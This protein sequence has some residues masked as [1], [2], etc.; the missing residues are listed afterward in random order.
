M[1]CK[2]Y[3]YWQISQA[4][5]F[6][7]GFLLLFFS[8]NL[9]AQ[10]FSTLSLG[11]NFSDI[12]GVQSETFDVNR[13]FYVGLGYHTLFSDPFSFG[14]ELNMNR[15][16]FSN[17]YL[18]SYATRD[19]YYYNHVDQ[20]SL[21][22]PFLLTLHTNRFSFETGP[23]LEF[24]LRSRQTEIERKV[25][26]MPHEEGVIENTYIDRQELNNTELGI[27]FGI[28]Y[29]ILSNIDLSARYIQVF[30]PPGREYNWQRQRVIQAGL[31]INFGKSFSPRKLNFDRGSTR[32]A[33]ADYRTLASSNVVRVIYRYMGEGN[34][35]VF[36]FR[37]TDKQHYNLSEM[38][39]GNSS[40]EL[41]L[42]EFESMVRNAGFPFFA[43]MR[44]SFE[45]PST[46]SA[47]NYHLNFEISRSGNWE[48]IIEY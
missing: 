5:S 32:T 25:Y 26:K 8:C 38:M 23:H 40:G 20:Y 36:R 46:R 21:Y 47:I 39:I 3:E 7:A 6:L 43:N 13:G 11:A 45:N 10:N 37:T 31:K 1:F 30:T 24:I 35:I 19:V 22:V 28:N 15:K 14:V 18:T 17:K 4:R 27:T 29:N 2:L 48:V 34:D 41:R 44:F 33:T 42:S 9:A 12:I 16:G